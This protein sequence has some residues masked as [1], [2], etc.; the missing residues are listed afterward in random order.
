MSIKKMVLVILIASLLLTGCVQEQVKTETTNI[1]AKKLAETEVTI[2]DMAGRTVTLNKTPE[3][4]VVLTSYWVETLR[5]LN[6]DD[7]IV[8]IGNYVPS[9]G[10]ISVWIHFRLHQGKTKSW[11]YI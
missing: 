10:Y 4:V 5:L 7:K 6:V 8:G 1:N 9:S 11:K 2:T 3:R